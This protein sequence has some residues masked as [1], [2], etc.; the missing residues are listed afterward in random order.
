MSSKDYK[1]AI[2]NLLLLIETDPQHLTIL[3]KAYVDL[4]EAHRHT[5][6]YKNGM[7]IYIYK[8]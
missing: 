4:A 7:Y 1:T 6:D 3:P 5:K 2:K 8:L